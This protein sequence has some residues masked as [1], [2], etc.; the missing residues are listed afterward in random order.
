MLIGFFITMFFLKNISRKGFEILNLSKNEIFL[1]GLIIN[2]LTILFYYILKI[3][4]TYPILFQLKYVFLFFGFGLF[5]S[6]L[7]HG[8]VFLIHKV[9]LS[10]YV[11]FCYYN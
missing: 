6:S 11:K 8:K 1:Y 9:Y 3:Q 5:T 2:L 10:I 4:L 7:V